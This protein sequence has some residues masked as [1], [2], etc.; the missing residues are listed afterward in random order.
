MHC[1]Y[2]WLKRNQAWSGTVSFALFLFYAGKLICFPNSGVWKQAK[3]VMWSKNVI[4]QMKSEVRQSMCLVYL[5]VCSPPIEVFSNKFLNILFK[6]SATDAIFAHVVQN[7]AFRVKSETYK[8][9]VI[10]SP[11][12]CI[13]LCTP[14]L[15]PG[16]NNNVYNNKVLN[17]VKCGQNCTSLRRYSPTY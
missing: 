9:Q 8:L 17:I 14:L 1:K 4:Y 10:S 2:I 11:Y 13:L 3:Y 5:Y 16:T 7:A 15:H 6:V 12:N